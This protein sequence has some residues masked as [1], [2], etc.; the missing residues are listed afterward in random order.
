MTYTISIHVLREE[1]D[2]ENHKA[3]IV[4]NISIHVLREEDDVIQKHFSNLRY[5]FQS[6]SSAR[7]TTSSRGFQLRRS[8]YF[9][10]RPPRGGRLTQMGSIQTAVEISIHVLRE[11]DDPDC[12]ADRGCQADFNPRP[13]R[14]GRPRDGSG[15]AAAAFI[16]I[17][18]LREEDDIALQ[19]CYG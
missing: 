8:P 3:V 16:S 18:V 14:G 5:K 10:P 4:H 12:R 11:E 13:P 19:W 2:R 15:D 7:R 1:D 9:N 6:T 17:H